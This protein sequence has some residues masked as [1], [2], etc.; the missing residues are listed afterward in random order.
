MKPKEDP[1]AAVTLAV[2]FPTFSIPLLHSDKLPL[3]AATSPDDFAAELLTT[4]DVFVNR[5]G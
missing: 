2:Y 4:R 1:G 3:M 5:D